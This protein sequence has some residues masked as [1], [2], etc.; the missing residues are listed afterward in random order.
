MKPT[1][2]ELEILQLLWELGPSTVRAV[3]ERL[4]ERRDVGYTTTLKLLQIMFEKG[5]VSRKEDGRTH[6]YTAAITETDTQTVLLQE[7]VD[8]TFRGSAMKM[9]MQALGNHDASTEEL[10]E[11]KAL[12]AQME[13]QNKL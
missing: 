7:F 4:N 2:S 13:Q 1:D 5:I 10:D 3:N 8:Q 12:I 6:T 9:V 11:I